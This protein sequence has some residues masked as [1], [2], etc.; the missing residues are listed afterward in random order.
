MSARPDEADPSGGVS[1]NPKRRRVHSDI[2]RMHDDD[3]SAT[4]HDERMES[5]AEEAAKFAK[6]N[7]GV[8]ADEEGAAGHATPKFLDTDNSVAYSITK[9]P[10][11]EPAPA[12]V[13][14]LWNEV[15]ADLAKENKLG[16]CLVVNVALQ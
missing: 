7:K 16:E 5:L 14:S 1:P 13:L 3:N 10:F 8:E 11:T 6:E 4:S 9:L 2:D 12:C 15:A